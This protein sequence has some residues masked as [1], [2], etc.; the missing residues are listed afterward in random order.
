[1][2][3]TRLLRPVIAPAVCAP[4]LG[5]IHHIDASSWSNVWV[6]VQNPATGS[7]PF[8]HGT[9]TVLLYR[10]DGSVWTYLTYTISGHTLWCGGLRVF[11]A[12]DVWLLVLD[13]FVN[14]S[15][16]L[17]WDGS[18]WTDRT[19]GGGSPYGAIAGNSSSDFWFV[20][21]D[22]GG[23]GRINYHHW[24]G[25]AWTSGFTATLNLTPG[26]PARGYVTNRCGPLAFENSTGEIYFHT[27]TTGSVSR[28]RKLT[29]AFASSQAFAETVFS[30][31]AVWALWRQSD[32]AAWIVGNTFDFGLGQI[33][34]IIWTGMNTTWTSVTPP[35]YYLAL[36]VG[37]SEAVIDM[38]GI[39]GLDS[40]DFLICGNFSVTS[41]S[42]NSWGI[43]RR[44]GGVWTHYDSTSDPG[45]TQGTLESIKYIS[46]SDIWVVG[47]YSCAVPPYGP[48]TLIYHWNGSAWSV[49][50]LPVL[51]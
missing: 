46:S 8:P 7:N 22:S 12:N 20:R 26:A 30:G 48:H 39:G 50:T 9:D 25:A 10:W 42:Y 4:H 13:N 11:G 15:L 5:E 41:T 31:G 45:L 16:V 35:N 40:T 14:Q 27:Y 44:V 38:H 6:T 28:L 49:I 34:P 1:M 32:S 47:W 51:P 3:F 36:P 17:H 24:T 37:I 23:I 18:S 33:L 2:T 29:A 43:D 19:P 21:A